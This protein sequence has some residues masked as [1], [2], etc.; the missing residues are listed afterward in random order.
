LS[1]IDLEVI[2]KAEF[3]ANPT[4]YPQKVIFIDEYDETMI[5][6]PYDV[7]SATSMN[8]IWDLKGQGKIFAFTATTSK[9][10]DRLTHKIFEYEPKV[11]NFLSEY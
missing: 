9:G 6:A 2:T 5:E 1:A 11:H 10:V 8:G 4:N 3:Y 7:R